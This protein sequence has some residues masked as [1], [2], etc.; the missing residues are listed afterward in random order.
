[1]TTPVSVPGDECLPRIDQI[2]VVSDYRRVR[3]PDAY[4]PLGDLL[5]TTLAMLAHPFLTV[6]TAI[7]RETTPAGLIELTVNELRRLFDGPPARRQTQQPRHAAGLVNL[8]PRTTMITIY[9]CSTGPR[10]IS[11]NDCSRSPGCWI[12]AGG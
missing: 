2:R 12:S 10:S 9:G 7:E 5:R 4:P 8:T 3:G 1:M 6:A 11:G